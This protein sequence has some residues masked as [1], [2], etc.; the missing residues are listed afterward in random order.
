MSMVGVWFTPACLHFCMKLAHHFQGWKTSELVARSIL[1]RT[2]R[3][4]ALSSFGFKG[5]Q[6]ENH[7]FGGPLQK[8]HPFYLTSIQWQRHGRR[9]SAAPL[10][11]PGPQ[12]ICGA[13]EGSTRVWGAFWSEV[14]LVGRLDRFRLP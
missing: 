10:L 3:T 7:H 13:Q 2:Q 8:R 6:Q 14:V 4:V 12:R 5:K 9:W 11:L 1:N